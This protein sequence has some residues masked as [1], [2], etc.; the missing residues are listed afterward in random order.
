[1]PSDLL[2]AFLYAQ[3]EARETVVA[4]REKVWSFYFDRLRHWAESRGVRLPHVPPSCQ[5]SYHMFYLILPSLEIR[6]ALIAH[7]KARG[8]PCCA[9]LFTTI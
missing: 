2:A 3:L 6:Q 7:L 5:Q 1:L 8:I 9:C 4:K